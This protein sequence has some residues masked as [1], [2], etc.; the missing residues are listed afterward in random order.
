MLDR[1]LD[2]SAAGRELELGGEAS[3]FSAA[4]LAELA[5]TSRRNCSLFI[6]EDIWVC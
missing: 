2:P 3:F 5:A 1:S 6:F 4:G